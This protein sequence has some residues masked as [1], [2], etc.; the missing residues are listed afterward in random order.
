MLHPVSNKARVSHKAQTNPPP[1]MLSQEDILGFLRDLCFIQATVW[2]LP[3]MH[4]VGISH[5]LP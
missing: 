2:L 4:M 1:S 5:F 3:S